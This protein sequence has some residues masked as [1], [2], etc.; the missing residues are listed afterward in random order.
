MSVSAVL[1]RTWKSVPIA[2]VADFNPRT[3][4]VLSS[5]ASL[6][7]HFVPMSAV[8]EEFGG[9]SISERRPLSDVQ[10]GY[11]SFLADDV[12]FAKI[13]PC[14]ENGKLAIVPTLP[15]QLAFGST[16]FHVLRASDAVLPTWLSY[17]LSQETFRRLARQNMTGSAGQMR[18]PTAWLSTARIPIAPLPEQIRI[19]GK[20]E[21]L[22][23]DLDAGVTELKAAQKKLAQYRQSLLKAAVEG[24]LTA[25]WRT[26]RA[27]RGE[28]IESGARLLARILTERRRRWEARQLEKFKEQGKLPP[29]NWQMKYIS[30][31]APNDPTNWKIPTDWCWT[32]IEQL[33]A[34]SPH[35]LKAGPF[36]SALKKEYYTSS[37]YKIYGQE[38]VIRGDASFGNYFISEE[39]YREL[40]ACAVKQGDVLISLVGTTG[41]VLILPENCQP[42]IINPR[43]LKIS[44]SLG[45]VDPHF[46]Q[47]V[48]ES[49]QARHFFKMQSHGGTM[50]ILNLG[51]L[52]QFSVPL[53]PL[54]EQREIVKD[55]VRKLIVLDRQNDAVDHTFK[56]CTAQRKNILKAAFSG[57]LVPQDPNDEPASVLLERIRAER[58]ESSG[59][60]R[61][62]NKF[63]EQA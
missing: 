51:I 30:P 55:F 58:A 46:I 14:M 52:K 18:V 26:E 11:T 21:E 63:K 39:R 6:P 28:A 17:F 59:K 34:G 24:A 16:E 36:G 57:Q 22:L 62:S 33:A 1:P 54:A 31:T 29:K 61:G 12:L 3:F 44:L 41:K 38:Q 25:E 37:G 47:L 35:S 49:P 42:G 9:I 4:S 40:L 8:T 53:P 50:E 23:S 20:L 32:G 13:T 56:Q 15:E 27:R 5:A 7:V 43:L 19:V 10:K 45:N 48:L 2:E 60:K